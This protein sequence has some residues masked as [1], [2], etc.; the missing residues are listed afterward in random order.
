[1]ASN[2]GKQVC[3]V[4]VVVV[5][6]AA[7][8]VAVFRVWAVSSPRPQWGLADLNYRGT[9]ERYYNSTQT[10]PDGSMQDS[11]LCQI[12]QHLDRINNEACWTWQT[13]L[14]M[15]HGIPLQFQTWKSSNGGDKGEGNHRRVWL[16]QGVISAWDKKEYR[17]ST[18]IFL[19]LLF[20]GFI[21]FLLFFV[22]KYHP[23]SC[24]MVHLASS[25]VKPI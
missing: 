17:H 5:S 11:S 22:L 1:M 12:K 20:S 13:S 6:A 23:L 7:V 25:W 24:A 3:V 18:D 16:P 19:L 8:V 9:N 10:G 21:F 2:G 4:V 14:L 15:Q